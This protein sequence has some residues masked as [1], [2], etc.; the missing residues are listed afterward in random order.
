MNKL[1]LLITGM[2]LSVTLNAQWIIEDKEAEVRT[3]SGDFNK[4]K[5]EGNLSVY[6]VQSEENQFAVSGNS[7]QSLKSVTSE[8]NDGVLKI[9]GGLSSSKSKVYIAFKEISTLELNG[10][11]NV[12]LTTNWLAETAYLNFN[13]II[14]FKGKV[15]MLNLN[16]EIEGVSKVTFDGDIKN[17]NLKCYGNSKFVGPDLMVDDAQVDIR[18][19]SKVEISSLKKLYGFVSGVS[20]M[21]YH[22][23][24]EIIDVKVTDNATLRRVQ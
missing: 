9:S 1:L 3:L 14:N 16:L 7:L 19:V 13:G 20:E 18:G 6:L 23:K 24:P 12:Q 8:I 2:L 5:V 4:I 11:I 21:I 15:Q 22:N 10:N 17:L